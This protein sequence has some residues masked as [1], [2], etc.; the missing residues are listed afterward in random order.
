MWNMWIKEHG[1]RELAV[2]MLD[3]FALD[4][5]RGNFC[6]LVR[7]SGRGETILLNI[8]GGLDRPTSGRVVLDG[9]EP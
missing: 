8:V 1:A 9:I 3:G 4:V 2:K 6:T 5:P 7:P